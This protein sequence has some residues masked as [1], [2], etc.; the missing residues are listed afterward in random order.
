MTT[1]AGKLLRIN[2]SDRT[3]Q[4]EDIPVSYYEQFISARGLSAL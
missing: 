2:L 4:V 3:D 1:F